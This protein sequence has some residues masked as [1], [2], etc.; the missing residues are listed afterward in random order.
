MESLTGLFEF[1]AVAF[2]ATAPVL[3]GVD[4]NV[5]AWIPATPIVDDGGNAD[6]AGCDAA[7]ATDGA[8]AANG[9]DAADAPEA[10]AVAHAAVIA[11]TEDAGTMLTNAPSTTTRLPRMA[12]PV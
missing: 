10:G 6:S 5:G 4:S 8:E 9:A 2:G 7:S 3:A 1:C 12:A 11:A